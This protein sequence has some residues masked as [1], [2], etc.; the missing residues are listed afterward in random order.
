MIANK[1]SENF[2]FPFLPG[3][4]KNINPTLHHHDLTLNILRKKANSR[5]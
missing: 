5:K 4:Y 2:N 1:L 3:G